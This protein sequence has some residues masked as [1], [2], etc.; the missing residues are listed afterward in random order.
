M[1]ACRCMRVN[2]FGLD[3]GKPSD[4]CLKVLDG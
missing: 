1:Q 3:R 2:A 4:E